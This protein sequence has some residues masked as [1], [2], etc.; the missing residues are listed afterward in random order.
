MRPNSHASE[1][2]TDKNL[3]VHGLG[4]IITRFPAKGLGGVLCVDSYKAHAISYAI[5]S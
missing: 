2:Q 5:H 1:L 3:F 4:N